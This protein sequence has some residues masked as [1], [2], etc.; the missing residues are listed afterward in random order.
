MKFSNLYFYTFKDTNTLT[1]R[2]DYIGGGG[3]GGGDK[4]QN[5]DLEIV[6]EESKQTEEK[7]ISLGPAGIHATS[8]IENNNNNNN[9]KNSEIKFRNLMSGWRKSSVELVTKSK[10]NSVSRNS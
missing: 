2:D 5:N 1:K 10:S 9:S 8:D 7:T 4:L 6:L 3:G